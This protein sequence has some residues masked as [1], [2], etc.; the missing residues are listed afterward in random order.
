MGLKTGPA[1]Q[2]KKTH[3]SVPGSK[4]SKHQYIVKPESRQIG[5]KVSSPDKASSIL[6]KVY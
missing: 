5:T 2:G 3:E 4:L 1:N 6:R